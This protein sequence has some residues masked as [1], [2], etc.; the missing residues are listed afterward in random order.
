MTYRIILAFNGHQ[1]ICVWRATQF[2]LNATIDTFVFL[3]F[4]R[5]INEL[6]GN[7]K[8]KREEA[9]KQ[10]MNL[11]SQLTKGNGEE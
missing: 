11:L 4:N 9:I 5:V 7:K 2:H 10:A 8:M 1:I 3:C 6:F